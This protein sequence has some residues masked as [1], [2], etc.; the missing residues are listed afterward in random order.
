MVLGFCEVTDCFQKVA[1]I[2]RNV[3][4]IILPFR[5][6]RSEPLPQLLSVPAHV[7]VNA[8]LSF[9]LMYKHLILISENENSD[10]SVIP[11]T[12]PHPPAEAGWNT[13]S[14]CHLDL[15]PDLPGGGGPTLV[16][17]YSWSTPALCQALVSGLMSSFLL[18]ALCLV[19]TSWLSCALF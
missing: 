17:S 8:S 13:L 16:D 18:T 2:C 9:A 11:V 15:R 6:K 1:T 4:I 14:L 12:H 19:C 5:R 10:F 7:F 3:N